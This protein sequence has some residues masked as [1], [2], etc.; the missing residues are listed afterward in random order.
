MGE[1]TNRVTPGPHGISDARAHEER[2]PG[3]PADPARTATPTPVGH[4][5]GRHLSTRELLSRI[6]HTASQLVSTEVALARA[7]GKAN[8]EAAFATVKLLVIAGVIGLAGVNLLLVAA[9]FALAHVMPGWLAALLLGS[10]IV[11]ISAIAGSI[12]GRMTD[13]PDAD[14]RRLLDTN[15]WGVVNGS[16]IAAEHLRHRGGALIN[17]GSTLSDRAIPGQGMYCAS[18]HAVKGFTDALRMELEEAGAPISVSLVKPAAIDTPYR[19]HARN[20]LPETPDNPP[21]VYAPEVVAEAI[22]HC[23]EHAVR[24]VFAGGGA[25]VMSALGYFAPRLLDTFME[26]TMVKLQQTGRPASTQP[27]DAL[28]HPQPASGLRERGGHPGHVLESSLYTR[29]SLHPL[30]TGGFFALAGLAAV[31]FCWPRAPRPWRRPMPSAWRIPK[32]LA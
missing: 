31:A 5:D 32:W 22:L 26:W 17:I 21:P 30:V 20:Y 24:E 13:V 12:Y 25:K 10:V 1:T 8:L 6:L 4:D 23:A 14:H 7:E 29:A 11:V 16:R 9:V 2:I 19:Q 15:F 3:T 28:F 27:D 18:K